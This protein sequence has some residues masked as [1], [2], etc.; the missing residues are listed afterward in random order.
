MEEVKNCNSRFVQSTDALQRCPKTPELRKKSGCI[1]K[2]I[3]CCSGQNDNRGWAETRAVHKS[4]LE[5]GVLVSFKVQGKPIGV[6]LAIRGCELPWASLI[7]NNH[8]SC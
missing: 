4:Y 1:Q 8:L 7:T 2:L 5:E 6:F 3:E